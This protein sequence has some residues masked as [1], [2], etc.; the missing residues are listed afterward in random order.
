MFEKLELSTSK[1]TTTNPKI[2]IVFHGIIVDQKQDIYFP[3]NRLIY[4]VSKMVSLVPSNL[5]YIPELICG[6]KSTLITHKVPD[7]EDQLFTWKQLITVFPQIDLE[8]EYDKIMG[9][10]YCEYGRK[11]VKFFNWLDLYNLIASNP[12][13]YQNIVSTIDQGVYHGIYLEELLQKIVLPKLEENSI[14]PENVDINVYSCRSICGSELTYE[15]VSDIGVLPQYGG[16]KDD[17][18]NVDDDELFK[19]LSTCQYIPKK[20]GHSVVKSSVI[21]NKKVSKGGNKKTKNSA[22]KSAKKSVNKTVK[23]KKVGKKNKKVGKKNKKVG[24]NKKH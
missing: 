14:N 19:Y 9:I 6:G 16:N 20:I 23:N 2:I 17:I 21:K 5:D 13:L 7:Y 15:Q 11:P 4:Y 24:K 18:V 10:Y 1:G 22:K 8:V 12:S 3:Y